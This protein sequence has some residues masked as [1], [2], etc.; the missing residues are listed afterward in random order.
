MPIN[1]WQSV[2]D[3]GTLI[4]NNVQQSTDQG[5]FTCEAR[6]R[7]GHVARGSVAISVMGKILNFD[8]NK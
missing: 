6:G 4:I 3:N 8:N 7:Q 5:T 2:A 1:K